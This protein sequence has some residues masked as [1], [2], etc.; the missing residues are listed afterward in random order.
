MLS[1]ALFLGKK[2]L[3]T[4]N[5]VIKFWKKQIPKVYLPCILWSLPLFALAIY[6]G[7]NILENLILLFCCGYSVYYFIALI[8]Q[9]YALLP[10]LQKFHR[11]GVIL[12]ALITAIS[13]IIFNYFIDV[14]LP[15]V[16]RVG[17]FVYWIVFFALGIELSNRKR[18]YSLILP[19]I[20]LVIGF[21]TQL[22]ETHY[23]MDLDKG[24][25]GIKVSA[26]IYASGTILIL[27][28]RKLEILYKERTIITKAVRYVGEL[29]FGLYLI[30]CYFITVINHF[31]PLLNWGYK[32]IM[33]VI[34][35]ILFIVCCKKI[36][37][38]LSKLIGF[39]Y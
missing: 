37:P 8:I 5:N 31:L 14:Q 2:D 35:S 3:S 30:H 34:L 22:Y 19:I 6:H 28:S 21:V 12:S 18:N 17:P 10:L 16:V 39:R 32:G 24:G 36:F 26:W 7:G 29:S 4:K 13:V 23:L 38:K 1:L 20:L 25:I 11:R 9:C 15:L 27:F 33:T